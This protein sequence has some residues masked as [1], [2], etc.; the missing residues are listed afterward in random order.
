MH[1]AT[2][3]NK[4]DPCSYV[5]A[6]N[7]TNSASITNALNIKNLPAMVYCGTYKAH[8]FKE[9][10]I[11][12]AVEETHAHSSVSKMQNLLKEFLLNYFFER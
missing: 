7:L 12:Q 8:N 5:L 4:V 10:T 3:I 11:P 2:W 9:I 1:H 6:K